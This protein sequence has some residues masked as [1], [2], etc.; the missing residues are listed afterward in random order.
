MSLVRQRARGACALGGCALLVSAAAAAQTGGDELLSSLNGSTLTG[1]NGGGGGAVGWLHHFDTDTLATLGAEHQV[2]AGANWTFGSVSVSH[3]LGPEDA[4]FGIV[5]EAHEGRG[6][7]PHPFSY[8]IEALAVSGTFS[9]RLT[10]LLEDR[11]IDVDTTRGNLPKASLAYLW[12]PHLQTSVSYQYT[13]SG[14]LG[15]R[16]TSVRLD[17]YQAR[18]NW[19]AGVAFG[20]GAPAIFGL[21]HTPGQ[22]A[23][24]SGELVPARLLHEQYL[25]FS[26]PV[27]P[28]HTDIGLLA[29]YLNLGGIKRATL[30][31]TVNYHLGATP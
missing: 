24:V 7:D 8:A 29:D 22:S 20:Q 25:G 3:T 5:G 6:T 30:T 31:L 13:V 11:A 26:A 15:T 14:N 10:A 21:L 19:L 17:G 23:P 27:H 9:R 16:L 2:L 4:R 28:W 18:F 12:S 1:T